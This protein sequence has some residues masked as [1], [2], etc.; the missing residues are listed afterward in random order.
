VLIPIVE[1]L[2]LQSG[3]IIRKAAH[4]HDEQG[5]LAATNHHW[6]MID[7]L[8][9]RDVEGATQSLTNDIS[10]SFDLI[11]GRLED[12]VEKGHNHG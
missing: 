1:S 4:I 9:R 12:E 10:R 11:R 3:A 8:E 2:W 5:G 7:A 6:S